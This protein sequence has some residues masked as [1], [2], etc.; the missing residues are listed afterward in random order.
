M[1]FDW[2]PFLRFTSCYFTRTWIHF[3]SESDCKSFF[4]SFRVMS[5]S[6]IIR[7]LIVLTLTFKKDVLSSCRKSITQIRLHFFSH[8]FLTNFLITLHISDHIDTMQLVR[9]IALSRFTKVLDDNEF[10]LS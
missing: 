10:C 6:D 1:T 7:S 4:V 8:F 3:C 9:C 5:D 2:K